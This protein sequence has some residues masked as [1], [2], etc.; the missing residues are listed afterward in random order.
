MKEI[1]NNI[2]SINIINIGEFDCCVYLIDT[3]SKDGLVLID[4]GMN[5]NSI[6][7]INKIGFDP[8]QINHCIITH[9]HI[10]HF[11]IANELEK[12]NENIKFYAHQLDS[13]WIEKKGYEDKNASSYLDGDFEH[14]RLE[15][16]IEGSF[17]T[18]KFGDYE[19][20]CIHI[21]GHT[22]GSMAI[23]LEI[24]TSKI[25][26][27]GDIIGCPLKLMDGDLEK[28]KESMQ[29]LLKLN[30]DLLCEGHMGVI[31]GKKKVSNFI[32]NCIEM[33]NYLHN[34]LEVDPDNK[35]D[36]DNL[37]VKQYELKIYDN[38]LD[39]CNYLLE[40]DPNNTKAKKLL[41]KIKK[42]NPPKLEFVK[43]YINEY[44]KYIQS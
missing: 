18:L 25:L 10:D 1:Y 13:N 38:A 40:L 39:S 42:H 5:I 44:F 30:L 21:P 20:R 2:Y 34:V 7:K 31:R 15:K 32:S 9:G 28:Y 8:I 22:P 43:N 12:I 27:G 35:D 37:C 41:K 17:G 6:L 24:E 4:T 19:L 23:L 29:K 3:Q 14:I 33:S 16:H 26:F 36:W 11:G